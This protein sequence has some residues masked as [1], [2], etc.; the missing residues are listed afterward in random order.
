MAAPV[1]RGS[2]GFELGPD[3]EMIVD[4]A[5]ER[6]RETAAV[7]VHW[8]AACWRQ[9]ENGKPAV[10]EGDASG[11]IGPVTS[12]IRSAIGQRIGHV[13]GGDRKLAFIAPAW[14]KQ[15]CDAAHQFAISF[16]RLEEVI[17]SSCNRRHSSSIAGE[18]G[19]NRLS[20]IWRLS[21]NPRVATSAM[22]FAT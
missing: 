12:G 11:R 21:P 18:T 19:F 16:R 1:R 10:A 9:V 7:A 14:P 5:V 13:P 2:G 3:I 22:P 6:H 17:R 4:F 15:A 20:C 8:L